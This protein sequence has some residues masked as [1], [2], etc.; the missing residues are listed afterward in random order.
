[1]GGVATGLF[2]FP[3]LEGARKS[4]RDLVSGLFSLPLMVRIRQYLVHAVLKDSQE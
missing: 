4:Y 1:M 2:S 3:L